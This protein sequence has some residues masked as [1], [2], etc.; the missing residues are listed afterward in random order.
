MLFRCLGTAFKT[1]VCWLFDNS[2]QFI[3]CTANSFR[4][5]RQMFIWSGSP[6]RQ[7]L[8][9]IY[10]VVKGLVICG[11]FSAGFAGRQQIGMPWLWLFLTMK[12]QLLQETSFYQYP[13]SLDGFI[14]HLFISHI[15]SSCLN[16][17]FVFAVDIFGDSQSLER[18]WIPGSLRFLTNAFVV[19]CVSELLWIISWRVSRLVCATLH[20][21]LQALSFSIQDNRVHDSG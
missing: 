18:F 19:W 12:Q 5:L 3:C 10:L 11:V 6:R 15:I 17:P 16:L 21:A 7:S 13:I 14:C 20:V 1:I 4:I 9:E 8:S 2:I